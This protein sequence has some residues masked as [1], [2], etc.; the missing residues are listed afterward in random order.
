MPKANSYAIGCING[1][2]INRGN[3]FNN[4]DTIC[5]WCKQITFTALKPAATELK[6]RLPSV[7]KLR[8]SKFNLYLNKRIQSVYTTPFLIAFCYKFNN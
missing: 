6:H 5:K 7:C 2:I 3:T 8:Q 1:V 4:V